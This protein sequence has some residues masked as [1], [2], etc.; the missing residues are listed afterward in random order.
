MQKIYILFLLM[1][2]GS[3]SCTEWRLFGDN[4]EQT[5]QM[6]ELK[7]FHNIHIDGLFLV[8]IYQNGENKL[9][10]KGTPDQIKHTN[11]EV[12]EQTLFINYPASRQWRSDYQK[13]QLELYVDSLEQIENRQPITLTTK[14]TLKSDKIRFLF[15]GEL[16]RAEIFINSNHLY[17]RNSLTSTGKIT[18]KGKAA[19]SRIAIEG[20]THLDAKYLLTQN[21]RI[22]QYSTADSY[23]CTKKILD[24]ISHGSG[25]V[26][27]LGNPAEINTDLKSS[28]NVFRYQNED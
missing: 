11:A 24:V 28:G 16:N 5:E 7:P 10:V 13:V 25:D 15:L 2:A 17:L 9:I 26:Y 3:L 18:I 27:Y 14:D 23:V 4:E 12:K 1:L 22:I 20:S 19:T 8:D 6:K 21:T